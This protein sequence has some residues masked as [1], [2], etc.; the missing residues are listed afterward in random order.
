MPSNQIT[1]IVPSI[2]PW[3][4]DDIGTFNQICRVIRPNPVRW[5]AID[6]G[7][8]RVESQAGLKCCHGPAVNLLSKYLLGVIQGPQ[9]RDIG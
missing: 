5:E 6:N 1:S 8:F 9:N 2:L 7:T 4:L 3:C